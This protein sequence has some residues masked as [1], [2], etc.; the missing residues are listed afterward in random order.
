MLFKKTKKN[1]YI[2]IF[3]QFVKNNTN[4]LKG[5]SHGIFCT[6]VFLQTNPPGPIRHVL[7]AKLWTF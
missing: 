2:A 4:S 6:W 1:F 3:L 7:L 5:Q